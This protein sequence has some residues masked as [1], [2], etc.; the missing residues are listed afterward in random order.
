MGKLT[1]IIIGL[2]LYFIGGW[3]AKDIIFSMIEITEETTLGE[4]L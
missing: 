4:I 1:W 2:V 3:I